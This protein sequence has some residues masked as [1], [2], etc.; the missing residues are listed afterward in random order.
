MKTRVIARGRLPDNGL[1]PVLEPGEECQNWTDEVERTSIAD[2]PLDGVLG[3][4]LVAGTDAGVCLSAPG[5]TLTGAGHDDVKVHAV[6]TDRRVVL[7]TQ[8]NV[9]VDAETKVAGLGKV[10]L[11]QLV[12]LDLEAALENLLGLWTAD[13]DVHGD[14][15][16]TAD[17]K[18]TD[19]VA[20]L[21]CGRKVS[22]EMFFLICV[23]SFET[24][25]VLSLVLLPPLL[26][27][28]VGGGNVL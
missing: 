7:D 19:G 23:P 10:A 5:D 12:L 15:F 1:E 28:A 20:G 2:L 6:D 16:V 14:L 27:P 22:V 26:E 9:L 3:V 21:A 24:V 18:G 4:D 8:V 25:V 11:A 17:T 13:G